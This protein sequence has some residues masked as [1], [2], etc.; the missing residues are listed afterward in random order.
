MSC[1]EDTALQSSGMPATGGGMWVLVVGPSG[2]GKD[3]LMRLASEMLADC[4]CIIFAKRVVTRPQNAFEDHETASEEDFL[5]M[6]NA[7][8]FIVSWQAHGLSYG[9][10]RRLQ[11]NV[12]DGSIVVC[13]VSRS[14][15]ADAR[16]RLGRV[17]VVLITAPDDLLAARITARGRDK[18]AGSRTSRSPDRTAAEQADIVIHNVGLPHD[19]A[20][21]LRDYLKSLAGC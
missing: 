17:A 15:V 1:K 5:A 6:Q 3:T 13:N 4:P 7:A 14:I 20:M 18:A 19:G 12:N 21:R 16:Q 9:L 2:A 8:Q 10:H 11:D